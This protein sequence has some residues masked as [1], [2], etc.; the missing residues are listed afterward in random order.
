MSTSDAYRSRELW[1]APFLSSIVT[2]SL[3]HFMRKR[4]S[5]ILILLLDALSL[6]S[7]NFGLCGG[8]RESYTSAKIEASK[9]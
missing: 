7:M 6:L 1:G 4:T 8:R 5:F 9:V 2:L 3:M